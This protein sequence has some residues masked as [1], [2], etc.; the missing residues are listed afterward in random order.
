MRFNKSEIFIKCELSKTH[1]IGGVMDIKKIITIDKYKIEL[2]LPDKTRDLKF[3]SGDNIQIYNKNGQFIW[4]ISELLRNYSDRNG[5]KYYSDMYFDI[6][7]LDNQN[8]FCVGFI[9]HCEIDL[10]AGTIVRI[11]NNR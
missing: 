3:S 7:L 2:T 8:I 11:V 5:L 4:N 1:T 9:N 6:R 10:K